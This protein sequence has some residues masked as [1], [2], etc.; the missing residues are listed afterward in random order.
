MAVVRVGVRRSPLVPG[1][2]GIESGQEWVE[3]NGVRLPAEWKLLR[4]DYVPA[5]GNESPSNHVAEVTIRLL[6]EGFS[7]VDRNE[8][9][10]VLMAWPGETEST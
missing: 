5:P 10:G 3:L 1:E 4:V 6:C 9:P 8:P 7:T 2:R